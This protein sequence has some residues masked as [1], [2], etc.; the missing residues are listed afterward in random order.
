MRIR[1]ARIGDLEAV[2]GLWAE[3]M[4]FHAARDQYYQVCE[5]AESKYRQFAHSNLSDATKIFLVA[6]END[7]IVGFVLGER[8]AYPPVYDS[9]PYGEVLE[10]AVDGEERRKGVGEQL[11][12]TLCQK[13]TV[14]GIENI[15]CHVSSANPVSNNFWKK[16]G[17]REM[18]KQYHKYI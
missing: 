14:Q 13:F 10:I 5:G 17:F 2:V 11:L 16:M 12:E 15:E 8:L 4:R 7:K 18:M 9:E 6:E 3:M 1:E